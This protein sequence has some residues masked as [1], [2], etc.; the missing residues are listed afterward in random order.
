MT[1]ESWVAL[2]RQR[3]QDG[4]AGKVGDGKGWCRLL[5][6]LPLE[7]PSGTNGRTVSRKWIGRLCVRIPV[8]G[9]RLFGKQAGLL[10]LNL[11]QHLRARE[12]DSYRSCVDWQVGGR[13]RGHGSDDPSSP[14][15]LPSALLDL[16]LVLTE[17][18]EEPSLLAQRRRT[19]ERGRGIVLIL[20]SRYHPFLF[21]SR[22]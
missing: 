5:S 4:G 22:E 6:P 9:L 12:L 18:W 3:V 8:S 20:G 17:L 16:W 19:V 11:P 13:V 10:S 2:S 7:D 1:G 21:Y 14:H 15:L